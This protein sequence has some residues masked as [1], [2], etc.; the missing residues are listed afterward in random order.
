MNEAIKAYM[1]IPSGFR[2]YIQEGFDGW[3]FVFFLYVV[4][5]G[6][7]AIVSGDS[8]KEG[9]YIFLQPIF[10]LI[11][12]SILA[13]ISAIVVGADEPIIKG[14]RLVGLCL[15]PIGLMIYL[16]AE[17]SQLAAFG[18]YPALL[19]IVGS[20]FLSRSSRI[21]NILP[22]VLVVG[23]TAAL[24]YIHST[25]TDEWFGQELTF[26]NYAVRI[27][28]ASAFS[29]IESRVYRFLLTAPPNHGYIPQVDEI[30]DS[31]GIRRVDVRNALMALDSKGRI[32]L[33][34]DS[35][36]RYAYPWASFD[37]G[38][39]VLIQRTANSR[40]IRIH[41]ASALHA[42]SI[43][44]IIDGARMRILSRLH[45]TGQI[46]EI[47]IHDGKIDT[48]NFPEAQVYKSDIISEMEFY[49]SPAGAKA[50][51]RGRFDSTKLLDLERAMIVAE[52]MVRKKADGVL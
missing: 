25:E 5:S 50:S 9:I 3:R 2:N 40:T 11:V 17:K 6:I 33:G 47:D 22:A 48:T 32:V 15:P 44:L 37:N 52:E 21:L 1:F 4:F 35:E 29:E 20:M 28:K 30:A 49:S 16:L 43:P 31:L 19:F 26:S 45:D 7:L 34:A 46:I 10:L 18:I 41:A 27:S 23:L 13:A 51:Y 12:L 39:D 42:L 36:I 14:M 8:I 24:S 38:H